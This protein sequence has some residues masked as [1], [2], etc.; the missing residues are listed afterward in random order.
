MKTIIFLLMPFI[1]ILGIYIVV[2]DKDIHFYNFALNLNMLDFAKFDMDKLYDIKN[3]FNVFKDI[4]FNWSSF[5]DIL[6]SVRNI[7]KVVE[8]LF[9]LARSIG[10]LVIYLVR[11]ILD[12]VF[13]VA[14]YF[15]R[16]L[17][18]D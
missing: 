12:N 3:D 2:S 8:N 7:G 1:I 15:R 5:R 16:C 4:S 13:V 14:N 11:Y 6:K 10:N 17:L 9:S 18:M